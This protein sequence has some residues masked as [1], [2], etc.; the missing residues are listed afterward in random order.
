MG[1]NERDYANPD[2]TDDYIPTTSA[3]GEESV[4]TQ[5]VKAQDLPRYRK[6]AVRDATPN[7]EI[8]DDPVT[9][10]NG[11]APNPP[12]RSSA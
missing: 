5:H 3:G 9:D 7:R 8:P 12:T 10:R 11:R 4:E 1:R 2:D 6:P